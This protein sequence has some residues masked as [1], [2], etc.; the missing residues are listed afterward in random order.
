[1]G[2]PFRRRG[3]A[4]GG[5]RH[6]AASTTG[7][8]RTGSWSYKEARTAEKQKFSERTLRHMECA[9]NLVNTLKLLANQQMGGDS[10]AEV[11]VEGFQERSRFK[12][13]EEVRMFT[14]M[15]CHEAVKI[16]DLDKA[17]ASLVVVKA[18]FT[19][20]VPVVELREGAGELTLQREEEGTLRTFID[21][22]Y[23]GEDSAGG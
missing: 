11:L 9:T 22:T 17:Q 15:D 19:T 16:G 2:T 1:M 12:M 6:G 10:P 14:T 23:C 7:E 4:T 20:D 21:T 8:I 5:V 18:K 3:T 13:M